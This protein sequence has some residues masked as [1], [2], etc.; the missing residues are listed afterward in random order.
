MATRLAREF[1]QEFLLVHAVF[2][3]FAAVDEYDGNLVGELASE[4]VIGVDINLAPFKTAAALELGQAFFHDLAQMAAPARVDH[5]LTGL[6]DGLGTHM[7]EL[8]E[9]SKPEMQFPS[10]S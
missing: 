2:E 4:I 10:E 5:D 3:G 7:Q 1:A 8:R 9:S 6:G